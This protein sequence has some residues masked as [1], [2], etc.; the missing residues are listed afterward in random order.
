VIHNQVYA[1]CLGLVGGFFGMTA[2]LFPAS[3]SRL[4]IWSYY[5]GLSPLTYHYA[6]ETLDIVRRTVD[7][8]VLFALLMVTM[9]VYLVGSVHMSRKDV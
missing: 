9:F 4:L 7:V 6:D 8:Q 1:L 5:S 3:F 2:D